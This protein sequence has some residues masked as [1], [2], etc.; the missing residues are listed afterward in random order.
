MQ[1]T[2]FL[3]ETTVD[4]KRI[5]QMQTEKKKSLKRV[6]IAG[7]DLFR[8]DGKEIGYKKKAI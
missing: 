1:E 8:T 2:A 7:P 5:A 4:D 6:Y 3:V